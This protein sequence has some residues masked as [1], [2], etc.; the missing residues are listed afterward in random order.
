MRYDKPP[1][2]FTQQLD[3]LKSRGLII[4]DE[5]IAIHYLSTVS[6]YRLEGFWW[7]LQSDKLNHVF[8]QGSTF[9]QVIQ[10]YN[11]DR[12]LRLL[13]NDVVERIEIGLRTKIVYNLS[14]E[15]GP[16]WFEEASNFESIQKYKENIATIDRELKYSQEVFIKEHK[17]KYFL[18][19]RRPPSWKTF[20]VVSMGTLSK[21]YACLKNSINSKDLIAKELGVANHTYLPSW[22]HC[23]TLIRNICA[24][25]SRLWNKNLPGTPK[26][27]NKPPFLWI[28]AVP[29]SSEFHMLYIHLCCMKYL[30]NVLNPGNHFSQ[31]LINL[32][33]KYPSIDPKAL[34]IKSN[35]SNEPLWSI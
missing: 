20:E 13:L 27:L 8:K 29:K 30:L 14:H 12:E 23:I 34:G 5:A 32:L 15:L 10:I 2:S 24:H 35:W 33:E 26:L 16:W 21:V 17:K 9:E 18:D 11:F 3:K 19:D 31:K 4:N 1:L 6:Y 28:K 7:P 25:H 22:L